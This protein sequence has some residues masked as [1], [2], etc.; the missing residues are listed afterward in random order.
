MVV[1]VPPA[2]LPRRR[3]PGRAV[4]LALL[5]VVAACSG[6]D[7]G[8]EGTTAPPAS[9]T[10]GP[11]VVGTS[12]IPT[13]STTPPVAPSTS[14]LPVSPGE[15][16]V[17]DATLA[18][19]GTLD[20]EAALALVAAGYAPI[21]GVIAA[22]APLLDGGPALR[23]VLAHADD[24][25]ADQAVV[26]AAITEPPAIPLEKALTSA[27]PRLAAA[28]GIVTAAFTRFAQGGAQPLPSDVRVTMLELPYDDGDGPHGFSS[29]ESH[30]TA[31]ALGD[32][33]DPECRIRVNATSTLDPAAGYADPAFVATLAQEAFH[34]L[35]DAVA[36][37]LADAPVWVVEGGAAFAGEDVAGTSALSRSWWQRWIGEP[38]RPLD[39]RTYD[40]IGFFATIAETANAYPFAEALLGDPSAESVRR[41][42][43]LTDVF[44]R[45]GTHYATEP[46]WGPAFTFSA[47]ATAGL[48]APQQTVT[49]SVDGSPT[50]L[51][52]PALSELSATPFR[53]TAPGDV[54]VVTASPADRGVLRFGDGQTAVLNDANRSYCLLATGC[55]CPGAAAGSL[56]IT[57]VASTD[58]FIGLGPSAGGGPTLAARSLAQWCQEVL[59]PA[60]PAGALD[61]CLVGD[62]TSRAYVAPVTAGVVQTVTGGSGALIGFAADRTV[63]VDMSATT[64]VVITGTNPD[65]ST[66]TTTLTY[67]G[68]GTGTWSAADGVVA[69][70]G[71]DTSTFDVGVRIELVDGVV[72]DQDLPLTDVSLANYAG[73]LGTGRYQ[74]TPVSLTLAHV[75]P[76]V[77]G[78]AAFELAP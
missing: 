24:L 20:L 68:A 49:L 26:L 76:G 11:T 32:E 60:P 9:A 51:T 37:V 1:R 43:E 35:Q 16:G 72:I 6:D 65:G 57:D 2:G 58:V 77:G 62:W 33:V 45:W 67:R 50:V 56:S 48:T 39:R 3:H 69:V 52:S 19:D 12:T 31:L 40:A 41:R 64:P 22:A 73:L 14:A 38:Q 55:T 5:L 21:P 42:L 74:C 47:P 66:S 25:R 18:P 53:V 78:T 13:P 30:A 27:S 10:P 23:T 29:P 17:L 71:V 61:Q 54:L 46:S 44:D 7:D 28:A 70:A 75:V 34:C 8:T 63:H 59:V 4:A 15:L 36:P